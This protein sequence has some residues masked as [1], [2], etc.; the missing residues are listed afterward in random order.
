M[1]TPNFLES[2]VSQIPAIQLESP[3]T[4]IVAHYR[5]TAADAIQSIAPRWQKLRKFGLL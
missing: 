1:S 4:A 3:G 5:Q 2:H